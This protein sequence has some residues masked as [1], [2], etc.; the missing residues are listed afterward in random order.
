MS[1]DLGFLLPSSRE[2]PGSWRVIAPPDRIWRDPLEV[3][4]EVVAGLQAVATSLN[5]RM[6]VDEAALKLYLGLPEAP[7]A[8][9]KP[10]PGSAGGL[11]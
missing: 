2:Q 10:P 11:L 8:P 5:L 3:S 1:F 4:A 9:P 6:T 7:S